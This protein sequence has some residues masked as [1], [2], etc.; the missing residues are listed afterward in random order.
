LSAG[1]RAQRRVA[2]RHD[3]PIG[4]VALV[5]AGAAALIG[6]TALAADQAMWPEGRGSSEFQ[7][8]CSGCHSAEAAVN[9][10][11]RSRERWQQVVDDMV[12]R[13][14]EGSDEE[15]KLVVEYLTEHFGPPSVRR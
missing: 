14:A 15:L 4:A 8:V 2:L 7:R 10:T 1:G 11:R 13:G 3:Q 9:G 12:V 5:L 6:A